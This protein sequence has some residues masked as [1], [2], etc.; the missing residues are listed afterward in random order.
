[1]RI[2]RISAFSVELPYAGGSYG[3]SLDALASAESIVVRVDTDEGASGWGEV[4]PLGATYLPASAGSVHAGLALLAPALLGEDPRQTG[5]IRQRMD[6]VMRGQPH[7]KSPLDIACWDLLGHAT[8]LPFKLDESIATIADVHAARRDDACDAVG[9][10]LSKHGGITPARELRDLC[11]GLGLRMT[12]EDAW[13]GEIGTAAGL[14]L[15][16]STPPDLVLNSA[17]LH[18]YSAARVALDGPVV[19]DGRMSIGDAP[20]LGVTPDAGVLGAP[21]AVCERGGRPTTA[22]SGAGCR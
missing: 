16:L 18:Q 15:A 8:A 7:V 13:G 6:R 3:W 12:I 17:D 10:K 22:G 9:I 1:M 20:G 11:A 4:C 5:R 2:S 14:H 19:S 21:V